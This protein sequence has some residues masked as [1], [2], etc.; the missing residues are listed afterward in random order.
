M[1]KPTPSTTST[2]TPSTTTPEPKC[3]DRFFTCKRSK[4]MWDKNTLIS[5]F[6]PLF[7]SNFFSLS[8]YFSPSIIY[9]VFPS[10]IFIILSYLLSFITFFSFLPFSSLFFPF[11]FLTYS[12]FSLFFIVCNLFCYS[13]SI[14][15]RTKLWVHVKIFIPI[16]KILPEANFTWLI[17]LIFWILCQNCLPNQIY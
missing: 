7:F 15:P 13:F 6:F 10:F 9:S 8:S 14:S 5:Y 12:L 4:V 16:F 11:Q 1:K 17:F 2:T 3:D